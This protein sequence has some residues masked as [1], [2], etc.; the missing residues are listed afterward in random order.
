MRTKKLLFFVVCLILGLNINAQNDYLRVTDLSQIQNGS[1]IIFAARHDSLSPTAYYA[2]SNVASGKPQG[3]AFTS[4]S[5]DE[6]MTLPSEITDNDENFCWTVGVTNGNYTFINT[7]G[8]MIGYGTSGTDFVKNGTNSTWTI[9]HATS[10]TGTSVPNHNAFVITNVGASNRSIA[11]R[12]YSSGETYEKFAPYSNSA[13]NM[14]GTIYFFYIDIFVKSSDVTPMVSLPTFSPSGG[15]YTTTQNVTISCE[16]QGATIYYTLD[17]SAPTNESTVYSAPIEVATTTTIK[18]VA[19]KDGMINSGMATATY[20]IIETMTIVFYNNGDVME[21]RNIAKGEEIG[22][23][24]VATAPD[25]FT[26]TGWTYDEIQLFT[27]TSPSMVTATTEV[28]TDLNLYAVY[29]ISDNN[30]EEVEISSLNDSDVALIA[31]SKE[32]KYYAMSQIKGSNG[33]P[34]AYELMVSNGNILNAI[35]DDIKWNISYNDG[36]IIIYPNDNDENWLYCTSGNNNNSVRIGTNADN[37]IFEI[38]TVEIE[39]DIYPDYL[40]NK[41]TERFVGA[42]YDDGIAIDWRAYKLTASGAFPTNIKNQT[43]HY[44]KCEGVSYYC[45]N[46][47]V[48]S[49]QTITTN[50]TW[51]NVSVMNKIIVENDATLTINGIITC[52]NADNLI[53]KD[54]CQLVHNNKGL[55]ATVEKEIEGYGSSNAAWYTISS[56]LVGSSNVSDVEGLIPTTNNYDL[57][58]YDEPTSVWQNVKDESNNFNTLDSGRGY[59]YANEYDCTLSFAGEINSEDFVYD[60][61]KTDNIKLSGFNL[62]GNPFAHNIYKGIGAAIEGENL[63][64][65]YYI[66]SNS[67]AWNA[68]ISDD[69]PIK[70]SQSILVKTIKDGEIKINKITSQ[71]SS[72]Y[73]NDKLLSIFVENNDYNDVAY[74]SFEDGIGLEK[75]NHKNEDVPMIYVPVDDDDY[76]VAILEEN[77]K[78][79]PVYFEA[80]TMGE[81]TISV[82][83]NTKQFE[84]IYLL[85]N[86]TGEVTNMLL[87]DYKFVATTNDTPGRFVLKLYEYDSVDEIN[88]GDDFVYVNNNDLII[89]DLTIN[90]SIQIFDIQGRYVMKID[91]CMNNIERVSM[92]NFESGVYIIRKIDNKEVKTQKIIFHK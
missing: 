12:K 73:A 35:P 37:N 51:D 53:I 58:R 60:L 50:T 45:T 84:N 74:I 24:P 80:K 27:N 57:Y 1:S 11:F 39:D 89:Y 62:I 48:P 91:N 77:V 14:G 47:D 36:N 17:G 13:S 90:T 67:G 7:S 26:F 31:I 21:S 82:S 4:T 9:S 83:S 22:D 69:T 33:Q 46:I 85:D 88:N 68:R 16:T 61:S 5:S 43:Y 52:V 64:D 6:G 2:M 8:D 54:G 63:A 10:G 78:D 20:N 42:Y 75:I 15:D 66:L 23:L 65:G 81:Y 87:E 56:P 72:K 49:N 71:P 32:D 55:K 40:Y 18:A 19:M 34:T 44:F 29:S 76:A 59:L 79:I 30:C 38:K 92:D 41:S 70:P 28:E 86:L 3:V 25:G